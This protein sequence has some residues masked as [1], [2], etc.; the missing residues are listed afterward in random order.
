MIAACCIGFSQEANPI[1]VKFADGE[2]ERLGKFL[3][4]VTFVILGEKTFMFQFP[5]FFYG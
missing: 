3:M 4:L 2:K 5:C 1:I